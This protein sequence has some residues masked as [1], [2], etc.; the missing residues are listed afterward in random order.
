MPACP[1]TPRSRGAAP[2]WCSPR[3]WRRPRR[4]ARCTG[5]IDAT[6]LKVYG[7]GAWLAEKHGGRGTRT[8]RKLHRALGPNSGEL[9]ASELTSNEDGDA[10]QVGAL[11]GQIPGLPASATADGACDGEPIHQAVAERQP[12]PPW[13]WSS[14]HA[15]PPCRAQPRAPHPASATSTSR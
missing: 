9:L 7:A 4:A 8:W 6:G 14:R 15:P 2:A 12:D 11:L 10:S 13:R 3:R 5:V 1:T